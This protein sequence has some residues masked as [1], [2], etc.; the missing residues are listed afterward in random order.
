MYY[1][2][3]FSNKVENTNKIRIFFFFRRNFNMRSIIVNSKTYKII[4]INFLKKDYTKI[5]Y[6]LHLYYIYI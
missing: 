6:Y 3:H 5:I 4:K 2:I 1:I